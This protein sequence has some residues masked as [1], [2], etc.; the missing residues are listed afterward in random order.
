M[1]KVNLS[2]VSVAP[3]ADL[4]AN[5]T[6]KENIIKVP[7]TDLYEFK[8]HPFRVLDDE[9][10]EETV[11]SIKKLGVLEPA[12]V[13]PRKKGGYEIIS[14]HRRKRACEIAGLTEMPVKVMD[15]NDDEATEIM[16]DSN[17]HR[18][19]ILPSEKAHAYKMK[20]DAMKHQGKKNNTLTDLSES[21]G[22]GI[23]TIKRYICLARLNEALLDLVDCG[24]IPFMAAYDLSFLSE[25]H[26]EWLTDILGEKEIT[27]ISLAQAAAIRTASEK[28]KDFSPSDVVAVLLPEKKEKVKAFRF[29][30]NKV[31]DYFPSG[32]SSEEMEEIIYQLLDDWRSKKK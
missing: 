2:K 9:K 17:I 3:I 32:T 13:R 4:F 31:V 12:I 18:E 16:V 25:E 26:Q 22:E 24:G 23:K 5:D 21:T 27:K 30:N 11:E 1:S 14:G 6:A 20:F 8:G 19:T 28:K 15:Y 10:M 29:K 7:L